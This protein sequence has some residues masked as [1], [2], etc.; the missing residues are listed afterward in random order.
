MQLSK[1]NEY[2]FLFKDSINVY[3]IKDRDRAII[4]DFGSG[5]VL[6]YLPEIGVKKVDYIF[7]THYHRDQ[8]FGDQ[9][10]VEKKIKIAAPFKE[11]RLFEEAEE[12]WRTVTFYD[13][14]F[15]KPTYFVSPYNIP[16]SLSFKNNDTFEW[17]PYIFKIIETSGHTKGS[18]SYSLELNGDKAMFTGDII[19]SGGKVI[20]YY[21]LQYV[22]NDNGNEGINN[23]YQSFERILKE[24]PCILLPSHGDIIENPKNEIKTLTEKFERAKF[25][26]CTENS[27]ITNNDYFPEKMLPSV[28]L[29]KEFPHLLKKGTSFIILGN[30]NNCF[31]ND[32]A[33]PEFP[34]GYKL[35]WLERFLARKNIDKIDFVIPS[36][37]HDDHTAG[38][39]LLKKHFGAEIYALENIVDVLENPSHYRIGCLFHIPVTVDKVLKHGDVI[40]WDDYEFRIYHF[41]GQTEYHMGMFGVI[42]DKRVF[43]VGDSFS[44]STPFDRRNNVNSMNWCQLGKG[45]GYE[46]CADILL[47]CNPEYLAINHYGLIKVTRRM[48]QNFKEYVTE[49]EP[50]IS[51]IVAQENANFG[52][53]PNWICFNPIRV[54]VGLGELF[55]TNLIVRNYLD[56]KSKVEIKLNLPEGWK[57]NYNKIHTIKPNKFVEIPIS[58]STSNIKESVG[59]IILTANIVFNGLNLGPFP[60]LT[61]DYEYKSPEFWMGWTPGKGKSLDDWFEEESNRK[62]SFFKK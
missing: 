58:I 20:N 46:K 62:N 30:N 23:S 55:N 60:D 53:D 21:D 1:I 4:I 24:E 29:R 57:A 11:E 43:F 31:L 44:A 40:K 5:K 28:N 41:P 8:C 61:V 42:D 47:K 17:G 25:I 14:Y 45:V 52:F 9:K 38:L 32:Y 37:Y 6:D 2:L 49:Y 35:R 33:G 13:L 50:I 22:Y 59:R 16:I 39:S 18:V 12:F 19:H 34:Y 3:I 56:V 7:H 26:F 54:E 10:A 36:H 48:L 27:A 51:E 15:F